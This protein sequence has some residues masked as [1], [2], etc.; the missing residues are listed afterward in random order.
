[1]PARPLDVGAA[2]WPDRMACWVGS[3]MVEVIILGL[4][5]AATIAL[6]F[7]LRHHGGQDPATPISTFNDP[8]R[9]AVRRT[10][11]GVWLIVV[12][13]VLLGGYAAFQIV[14]MEYGGV[15]HV[16]LW[17]PIEDLYRSLGFW[18]AVMCVPVSGFLILLALLWKLRSIR[19]NPIND[20]DRSDSLN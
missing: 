4:L 11:T 10:Q 14:Q 2:G 7:L 16:R 9:G 5:G 15:E 1:M 19:T 18:P 17:R 6:G 12:A 20:W 13:I 3:T 8:S